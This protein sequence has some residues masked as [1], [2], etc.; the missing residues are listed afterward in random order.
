M[1]ILDENDPNALLYPT[2]KKTDEN[3]AHEYNIAL[4]NRDVLVPGIGE[5]VNFPLDFCMEDMVIDTVSK[6]YKAGIENYSEDANGKHFLIGIEACREGRKKLCCIGMRKITERIESTNDIDLNGLFAV[7]LLSFD[8]SVN[9]QQ[10]FLLMTK[11]KLY[12]LHNTNVIKSYGYDKIA[13]TSR[14]IEMKRG[15]LFVGRIL[16]YKFDKAFLN[17]A[18]EFM[19]MRCTTLVDVRE[20]HPFAN[21]IDDKKSP[22][23]VADMRLNI[24]EKDFCPNINKRNAYMS[25]L[26]DT[27]AA[28][29][30][31]EAETVMRL[32]YMAREFRISATSMLSWFKQASLGGICKNNLFSE[33]L[34]TLSFIG[35]K[36]K[37]IFVRDLL[38][39]GTDKAGLFHRQELLQILQY[40][41]FG[42][43]KF[44]TEYLAFIAKRNE[45]DRELMKAFQ[46]VEDREICFKH[47]VRAQNYG[48][49]LNLQLTTMGVV[50]GDTNSEN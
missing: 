50:I 44:V 31:L 43:K 36:Y 19:L 30:H 18:R 33:F 42:L 8:N 11:S 21:E 35:L 49:R 10:N 45:A 13:F 47:F 28:E 32:C 48:N 7:Y 24:D 4:V 17:F 25:F 16:Y 27:A 40:P 14:G 22:D 29:G 41:Q 15:D 37:F 46:S 2:I 39:A 20:R 23:M 1:K 3:V 26:V 9:N 34:R 12:L 38:E 6:K 5:T